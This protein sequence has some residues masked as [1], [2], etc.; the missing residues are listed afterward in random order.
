MSL[1]VP[2]KLQNAT[3]IL[4]SGY[5]PVKRDFTSVYICSAHS[6]CWSPRKLG[7][8]NDFIWKTKGKY[9]KTQIAIYGSF[10]LFPNESR[11]NLAAE[12]VSLLHLLS[13]PQ[14]IWKIT[15]LEWLR[16]WSHRGR[17]FWRPRDLVLPS[18]CAHT[19][20]KSAVFNERVG[21]ENLK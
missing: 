21:L 18:P 1:R 12:A 19:I 6:W 5:G 13:K 20:R 10:L 9:Y 3:E 15:E 17:H 11:K 4:V 2:C 7:S 14:V 8:A 16:M